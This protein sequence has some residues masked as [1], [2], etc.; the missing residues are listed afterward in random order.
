M[1]LVGRPSPDLKRLVGKRTLIIG[2]VGSGKTYY[3]ALLLTKLLPYF[4]KAIIIDMAPDLGD[5][6]LPLSRY[7]EIPP[8]VKYIRI[9]AMRGPRKEGTAPEEVIFLAQQN[10]SMIRPAL[11][12]FIEDPAP[13]LVINDLSMYLQAGPI[14]DLLL[15]LRLSQTF[16]G[17]SYYGKGL[18]EDKS[19]GIS[20]R[21]KE[22]VESLFSEMDFI[23]H[24]IG[25]IPLLYR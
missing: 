6:G 13:L 25:G 12:G 24:M 16:L 5:I 7:M 18:S 2:E 3:T 15:C 17:N 10:A 21:E 11:E 19:T 9:R 1:A 14:N 4:S 20:K 23:I 8:N 22:M